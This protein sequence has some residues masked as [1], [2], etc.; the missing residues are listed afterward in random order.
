MDWTH[1][2]DG[3][4]EP[5]VEVL[6]YSHQYAEYV[7]ASIMLLHDDGRPYWSADGSPE[8]KT[9]SHWAPLPDPPP[10]C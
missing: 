10:G 6:T 1:T 9:V 3:L 4:P 7:V 5:D 2:K 8:L